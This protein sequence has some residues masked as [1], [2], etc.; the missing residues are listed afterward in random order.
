MAISNRAA[1]TWAATNSS[2][3]LSVSIPAA[4]TTG[5]MMLLLV[6]W[7]FAA[8]TDYL[9]TP[10][11]WTL[12]GSSDN[13][14]STSTNGGGSVRSAIYYKQ[15]SGSESN[16]SL[17]WRASGGAAKAPSPGAAV[18]VVFQ[19]D[20]S[21][22]WTAS[23]STDGEDTDGG[24]SYS[25][26][27]AANPGIT[28]GDMCI[29]T[30]GISDN[31]TMTVPTFTATG[32][33]FGTV[34]E[35]PATALSSST[36]NDIACDACYRLASSGTASAA[37][38]V[39][40]TLAT[41]EPGNTQFI[42]LRVVPTVTGTFTANAI[43]KATVTPVLLTDLQDYAVAGQGLNYQ[44][45]ESISGARKIA[46]VSFYMNSSSSSGDV[47]LDIVSDLG[48]SALASV[49]KPATSIVTGW[50]E[51]VLSSPFSCVAGTTYY[52]R[53]SGSST[54]FVW[55]SGSDQYAG[56]AYW[57]KQSGSWVEDSTSDL[58]F[59]IFAPPLNVDAIVRAG[60]GTKT[61][62][63]DAQLKAVV[64]GSFSVDAIIHGVEAFSANAVI[65][66]N[67]GTETFTADAITRVSSGAL[68]LTANAVIQKTILTGVR[69]SYHSLAGPG[70]S[71]SGS[72]S[73]TH[74]IDS[75][76]KSMVVVTGRVEAT[77]DVVTSLTY[78]NK[79]M[80]RLAQADGASP[81]FSHIGIWYLADVSG[82][83]DDVARG[84]SSASIYLKSIAIAA[85][86]P[87]RYLSA[88]AYPGT[89]LNSSNMT[90]T[91]G[92]AGKDSLAFA[93]GSVNKTDADNL[94]SLAGQVTRWDGATGVGTC[95]KTDTEAITGTGS[96]G[97]YVSGSNYVS[98]VSI[99]VAADISPL[100]ADA[101]IK[102]NSVTKTLA[103]DAII[104]ITASGSFP[105]SAVIL[106][107]VT[108]GSFT[109]AA[110]IVTRDLIWSDDFQ[111]TETGVQTRYS[112]LDSAYPP[113]A[114]GVDADLYTQVSG[115][116]SLLTLVGYPAPYEYEVQFDFWANT[117]SDAMEAYEL[118]GP[119][120]FYVKVASDQDS[121]K[122]HVEL[123]NANSTSKSIT[124]GAY[125]RLKTRRVWDGEDGT[126][127][128]KFWQVGEAEPDWDVV[129]A[130]PT[131]AMSFPVW[132]MLNA[133]G[134]DLAF[135]NFSVWALGPGER[136]VSL[137]LDAVVTD[138]SAPVTVTGSFTSDTV[139]LATIPKSATADAVVLRNSGTLTK[140][141]DAVVLRSSGTL[142]LTADA[143]VKKA[144]SGS[145]SANSVIK[146]AATWTFTADAVVRKSQTSS[147]AADAVISKQQASSLVADAV[148][149]KTASYDFTVDTVFLETQSKSFTAEAEYVSGQVTVTDDFTSDA[150]LTAPR[151]GGFSV[152]AVVYEQQTG[153]LTV[154]AVLKKTA[155]SSVTVDVV[156]LET[157]SGTFSADAVLLRTT[158][159]SAVADAVLKRSQFASFVADADV[160]RNQVSA[161]SANSVHLKS[162]T[163]TFHAGA[164][165]VKTVA[166]SLAANAVVRSTKTFQFLV[167]G[168]VRDTQSGQYTVDAVL[169]SG[170]QDSLEV[171]AI[172]L[173][174]RS[175][176]LTQDATIRVTKSGSFVAEADLH[177]IQTGQYTLDADI[178]AVH[179]GSLTA[180]AVVMPVFTVDAVIMPVLTI[181]AWISIPGTVSSSITVDAV[182]VRERQGTYTADAVVRITS[183][184]DLDA[185]AA[186]RKTYQGSLT[187][188]ATIRSVEGGGWLVDSVVERESSGVL[189]TDAVIESTGQEAATADA[190]IRKTHADALLSD[191][192]I[193]KTGSDSLVIEAVAHRVA[194][195]ALPV[196]AV[197]LSPQMTMATADAIIAAPESG[198]LSSDA[199]ISLASAGSVT[200]DALLLLRATRSLWVDAVLLSVAERGFSADAVVMPTVSAD[201][202]IRSTTVGS[203]SSDAVI[204]PAL[205]VDALIR[206]TTTGS[207]T[208]DAWIPG[209]G[210][211]AF[212]ADGIVRHE[213]QGSVTSDAI[214]RRTSQSSIG[215]DAV[216][217]STLTGSLAGDA[218]IGKYQSSIITASAVIKSIH[219]TSVSSDAV[220]ERTTT[221]SFTVD[222]SISGAVQ[223]SVLADAVIRSSLPGSFTSNAVTKKTYDGQCTADAYII[224]TVPNTFST[225]AV[226]LGQASGIVSANAVT[227]KTAAA[228]YTIDAAIE[229]IVTASFGSDAIIEAARTVGLP[230]NAVFLSGQNASFTVD[231][232]TV[233]SATGS[234]SADAFLVSSFTIDA[235]IIAVGEGLFTIDAS[236]TPSIPYHLDW[237]DTTRFLDWTNETRFLDW[238]DATRF[239]DWTRSEYMGV[240]HTGDTGPDVTGYIHAE[241]APADH[242]VL[243]GAT[244]R[245]Q[246]RQE[247]DRSY[248]VNGAGIID[249]PL[250]GAVRYI[251]A[252]N[253]LNLKGTYRAQWEVTYPGG[254]VI[255][256]ASKELI[257]ERQ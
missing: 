142:T 6:H 32:V 221:G 193:R 62:A 173:G 243:T 205:L 204:M 124:G 237:V 218:V 23:A 76:V 224:R 60:S 200:L 164:V 130:A 192:V 33:T 211:G 72:W 143:V 59:A 30:T 190:V 1:G 220:I 98:M 50:N 35:Y 235:Y 160:R 140:T 57:T 165:L 234:F 147:L 10:S 232:V 75:T 246:M 202:I 46:S 132:L 102:A 55:R 256:T 188:D 158:S 180:N 66:A 16:P 156:V 7:K 114:Y 151:S 89:S 27:M 135:D 86:A 141:V 209:V 150:Y 152:S 115:A 97:F 126:D 179:L 162:K 139:I 63:A 137:T 129:A 206:K 153:A 64:P 99:S 20:A 181:D 58:A 226:L 155:S 244:V 8:T 170:Q 5:D 257:V 159:G 81:Y 3:A 26:T 230:A 163:D 182:F 31:Y 178:F 108:G 217:R 125:Y 207:L 240:F 104:G 167:D 251:W 70:G 118:D 122:W 13:G 161:F 56:G 111:R 84:S 219:A 253:D 100:T 183:S 171:D 92:A 109:A 255:T 233:Q 121:S 78:G 169:R 15:H 22:S 74:T 197:V 37:P 216:I 166:G 168:V 245:F 47:T 248:R 203:V 250:T 252:A 174:P 34:A 110:R 38:V 238:V 113:D 14:T 131:E 249:D 105:A 186:I 223:W 79:A 94:Q 36:G 194:Q 241:D 49:V 93:H 41:G 138:Q 208:V 65:S 148:V 45:A 214:A 91:A 128:A 101:V 117:P 222:A 176:D 112:V 17:Q 239:L 157:T 144:V 39:T 227:R 85:D 228:A 154:D 42:R 149:Q 106:A 24:T 191:A 242:E 4:A 69:P 96:E 189:T 51:F 136:N 11:G 172:V 199:V 103:A 82:R 52:L 29:A 80:T 90:L 127:A 201:A 19:K 213:A 247:N 119:G 18:I 107:T 9:D 2:T 12:A 254:K 88:N 187:S 48:G 195:G 133:G 225:D 43:I 68:T 71:V 54:D 77:G 236:I 177:A 123:W 21:E 25:A 83:D 28:A 210:I 229:K 184:G 185:D 134:V 40:H 215:G 175:G 212:T 53:I 231:A 116:P 87:T 145:F 95:F 73:W 120:G 146:K 198:S 67:S 44:R 61:F 196:D